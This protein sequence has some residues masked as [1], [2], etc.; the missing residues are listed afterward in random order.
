MI[1]PD[2]NLLIYAHNRGAPFHDRALAW[3]TELMNGQESVGIPWAV[4]CGF[5]RLCTHPAVLKSPMPHET[6]LDYVEAWFERRHVHALD[7][8]AEHVRLLREMLDAAG[9]AGRLTTDAHLA[10]LAVEY[11]CELHT[12]DSDF[13]RFPGLRSR[14]P[15]V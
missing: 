10:A 4:S 2:L 3:W 15:L 5:V 8:G 13:D 12:N 14:N 6:A 11:R 7:P 9:T 1:L